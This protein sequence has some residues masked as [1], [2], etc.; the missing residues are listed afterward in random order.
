[1]QLEHVA[2]GIPHEDAARAGAE[3]DWP[4]AQRIPGGVEPAR[5]PLEI[6]A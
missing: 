4:A 6:R 1:M 2:V 3:L 5:R